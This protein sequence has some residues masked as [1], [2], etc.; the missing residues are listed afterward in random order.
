[1][2]YEV[3]LFALKLIEDGDTDLFAEL[4]PMLNPNENHYVYI[5]TSIREDRPEIFELL[6]DDDRLIIDD[7]ISMYM[8]LER[9]P[10][11]QQIYIKRF[12]SPSIF[13]INEFRLADTV[14]Q[15]DLERFNI[16]LEALKP[17][18]KS[19]IIKSYLSEDDFSRIRFLKLMYRSDKVLLYKHLS[20]KEKEKYS[21]EFSKIDYLMS[22]S[23]FRKSRKI[24]K[25][26]YRKSD[27]EFKMISFDISNRGT[28]PLSEEH[29]LSINELNLC[30]IA[31]QSFL[32]SDCFVYRGLRLKT[33]QD[34]RLDLD[35][36][37]YATPDIRTA[38]DY[39]QRPAF[40]YDYKD[41]D[42]SEDP[43][44]VQVLLVI[45][46]SRGTLLICPDNETNNREV[47]LPEAYKLESWSAPKIF[48]ERIT[49]NYED[50]VIMMYLKLSEKK[51]KF[52]RS[53]ATVQRSKRL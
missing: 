28:R 22:P 18:E 33:I 45:K 48:P 1:M 15:Q 19:K 42:I 27:T 12:G 24:W 47:I 46:M 44:T 40:Q 3:Y 16:V 9:S 35:T 37:I 43:E 23:D 10:L 41:F 30:Y 13:V 38:L 32:T 39:A 31:N 7:H 17:K 21:F 25:V 14:Q 49:G 29:K 50:N 26:C 11:F 34:L 53:S 51:R 36:V 2:R 20:K 5:T 6:L 52:D 8:S 4:L